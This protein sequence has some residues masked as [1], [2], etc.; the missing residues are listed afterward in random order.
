MPQTFSGAKNPFLSE[1]DA[2]QNYNLSFLGTTGK[3]V[4][5]IDRNMKYK[6]YPSANKASVT[7]GI[8]NPCILK[9]LAD[10]ES[11]RAKYAGDY[12]FALASEV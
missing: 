7:L 1:L 11:K 12:C 6:V 5:A 2:L 10:D 9:C 4:V 8:S 3:P